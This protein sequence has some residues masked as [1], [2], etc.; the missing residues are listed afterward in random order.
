MAEKCMGCRIDWEGALVV[1]LDE[2]MGENSWAT[3]R[4]E[5]AGIDSVLA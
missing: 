4:L 2:E 3:C 5:C 1:M